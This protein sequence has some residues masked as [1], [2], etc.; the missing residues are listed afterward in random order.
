MF[1]T[2]KII[3][4]V[5][6]ISFYFCLL[7]S[8]FLSSFAFFFLS[9]LFVRFF[10]SIKVKTTNERNDTLTLVH[11]INFFFFFFSLKIVHR[12]EI[13]FNYFNLIFAS[14]V[15]NNFHT[16]FSRNKSDR[17]QSKTITLCRKN[18]TLKWAQLIVSFVCVSYKKKINKTKI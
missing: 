17:T 5:S 10:R 8:F 2:I 4:S 13:D 15:T 12:L 7:L 1:I 9:L 16:Q 11:K 18:H 3:V 14:Q 6:R